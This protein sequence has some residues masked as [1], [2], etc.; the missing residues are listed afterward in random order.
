MTQW[1]GGIGIVA[2][3]IVVLPFLRIGG[4]QLFQA[5]S[6]DRSEKVMPKTGDVVLSLFK[7]YCGLTFLCILT[8]HTL[9]MSWFDA[10]NH[11]LT[12][13]STGGYSTHD[14]SF[15]FFKGAPLQ[16][17]GTLFM[18]AGGLPFVLY[19]KLVYHGRFMFWKDEQVKTILAM[20]LAFTAVLTL[21][22]SAHSDY[23]ILDSLRLCAFN[24]VSI[25]TTTGY[26]TSDYLLWG[27]LAVTMF[28]FLTYLGAC[29]GST[30]GGLKV[31]RLVIVSKAVSRHFRTLLYPHGTF[32]MRYQGRPVERSVI[33]TVLGFLCLYVVANT[34]LTFALT[35]TGLDFAT[36]VSGAA[37]ALANVGPGVGNIIGPS[38]N[39]SALPDISKWLLC[40]GMLL[41]RLEILTVIVLF[42]FDFWND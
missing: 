26:A 10:L 9:G 8:Y 33:L 37:T 36:A 42:S 14:A 35:L 27:P 40:T 34:F 19:V 20:L 15:G 7:I 28:F 16:Y 5:E 23:A 24:V 22:L 29:A 13:L 41:G 17:A 12:T 18:L 38:G 21:W 3:A 31:M 25:V 2:F 30:T 39:F 4:M 32:T 11:A 6:S 1:I